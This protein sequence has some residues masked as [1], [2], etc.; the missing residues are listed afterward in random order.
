[1][2]ASVHSFL[3]ANDL[4]THGGNVLGCFAGKVTRI[5]PFAQK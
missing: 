1:M 2:H 3:C 5:A 4:L